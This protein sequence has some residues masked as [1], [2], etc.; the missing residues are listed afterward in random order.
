MRGDGW[1]GL[2]LHLP[3]GTSV[4]ESNV[5]PTPTIRKGERAGPG[6]VSFLLFLGREVGDKDEWRSMAE[7]EDSLRMDGS[8]VNERPSSAWDSFVWGC[9]GVDS[10]GSLI[11][12]L[13]WGSYNRTTDDRSTNQPRRPM[14]AGG[15]EIDRSTING[16]SS[17]AA[18]AVAAGA[19]RR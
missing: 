17:A 6:V 18:I 16:P 7:G 14:G 11:P 2:D 13:P 15:A 3:V 12:N 1:T 9:V 4:N 19:Y 8:S 5:R 10:M